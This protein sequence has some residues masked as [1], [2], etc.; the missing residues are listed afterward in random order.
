MSVPLTLPLTGKVALVTGASRGI[1]AAI[2]QRLARDGAKV[3]VNYLRRADRAGEVVSAIEA[4]GGEAFALQSDVSQVALAAPLVAQAVARFGRLD[5]LVNNAAMV[6]AASID[7]VDEALFDR[8]IATNV[9]SVLFLSQALARVVGDQGGVII[10]ISSIATRTANPRF[11]VYGATKA[12]VEML[13]TS[14]SRDLGRRGIRVNAVAPGDVD[15][16]MLRGAIPPEVIQADIER[17]SL[18]RLGLAEDIARV[19]AFLASDDARWITGETLHV[20]GGQR[21]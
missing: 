15:T 1:G 10:N 6:K 14:L 8:H 7:E 13:T 2:A 20:N 17:N 16:E 4:A 3:V 19:V 18:G 12:A 11:P 9:K 21:P 5:I